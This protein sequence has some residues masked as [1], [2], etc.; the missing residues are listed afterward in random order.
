VQD[1]QQL[2]VYEY[3][4]QLNHNEYQLLSEDNDWLKDLL[5][6]QN[7]FKKSFFLSFFFS[8]QQDLDHDDEMEAL[9]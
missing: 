2:N 4:Q 3:H 5:Y 1:V 7:L 6:N 8:Y 9:H